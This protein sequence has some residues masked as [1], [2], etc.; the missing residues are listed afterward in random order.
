MLVKRWHYEMCSFHLPIDEVSITLE[1]V[2]CILHIPI[3]GE[4][5]IYD[6]QDGVVGLYELFECDEQDLHMSGHYDISWDHLNYDDLTVV[7]SII[8]VFPL[9]LDRRGSQIPSWMGQGHT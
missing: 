4:R 5:L 9:I 7:L 3:H 8:V 6:H 1:D 2:Q